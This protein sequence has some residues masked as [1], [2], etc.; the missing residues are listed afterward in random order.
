M[1]IRD[2]TGGDAERLGDGTRHPG[3]R[4]DFFDVEALAEED[5]TQPQGF[6]VAALRDEIGRRSGRS[7]ETVEGEFGELFHAAQ[8]RGGTFA[9]S[10]RA[11]SPYVNGWGEVRE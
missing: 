6:A 1:C 7:G 5:G 10:H 11:D 4:D 8:R 3:E 2:S 9:G